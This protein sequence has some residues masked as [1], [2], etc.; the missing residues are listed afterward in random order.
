MLTQ[1]DARKIANKLKAGIKPG[2]RH[3]L[4]IFRHKGIRIAQF[5]ISRGS[6]EQSH[7][8]I[9]RQLYITAKQCREFLECSLSLEQYVSILVA[10][11]L[12][13]P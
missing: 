8:Y 7:D 1:A 5:G 13:P 2:R 12:L 3:D 11:Q 6:K 4:A 10:K 9:S